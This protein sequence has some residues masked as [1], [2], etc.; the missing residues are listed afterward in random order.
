MKSPYS[1]F[2]H[3]VLSVC[4][5]RGKGWRFV[6]A[7]AQTVY[8]DDSG[9]D[10]KSRIVTAAFCVS[11]VA[12]WQ[13]FERRW[14]KI[15]IN[16]GFEHF[17]M[18]EF[19]ACKREKPCKQCIKGETTLKQHPWRRWT[20]KKRKN[21]LRQLAEAVIEFVEY[22][23]GL[24]YTKQDYDEHIRTSVARLYMTEPVAD[25]YFT[26][27]VQ[28]CG[29]ELA[30]WR[31]V[32]RIDTPLK[33]VFDLTP[34]KERDEI[35]KVFFG[36]ASGVPRFNGDGVEQWFIPES[37]SYESRKNVVQLLAADM[38][39][40]VTATIRAREVFRSGETLEMFQLAEL[41]VQTEHIRMGHTP[42]QSLAQWERDILSEAQK[43]HGRIPE[44]QPNDG[45]INEGHTQR[46]SGQTG[47][48]K[49]DQTTE[50]KTAIEGR[51]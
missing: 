5:N 26:F 13:Q 20:A 10:T 39:A 47:S 28:R 40:W 27:A 15:S 12:K 16:A 4:S 48:R 7:D 2:E 6:M 31:A 30:K 38:L 19:A 45:T 25:Q 3:L 50:E 33:F 44:I 11:T 34:K 21:V 1:S 9:T 36:A 42:K 51:K 41:F 46:D 17:H 8:I 14:R 18:T 37:V 49:V 23:V 35:A 22:G 29:G 43:Q 32:K 24:A